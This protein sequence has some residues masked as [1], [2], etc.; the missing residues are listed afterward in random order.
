MDGCF[1]HAPTIPAPLYALFECMFAAITPLLITGA[2]AERLT[3]KAFLLF[4]SLWSLLVYYPV[5]RWIW[6]RGWLQSMGAL[7]FA[8]G[9]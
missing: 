3:F 7:D 9:V 2:F 5:A 6:G 4:V 1:I 8:G